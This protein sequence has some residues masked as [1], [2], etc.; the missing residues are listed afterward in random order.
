MARVHG[1]EMKRRS[2]HE[3]SGLI[4][5][6]LGVIRVTWH[7]VEPR[8]TVPIQFGPG[9]ERS[10]PSRIQR[11][12]APPKFF[13]RELRRKLNHF[14]RRPWWPPVF[15][16]TLDEIVPHFLVR[17]AFTHDPVSYI[18]TVRPHSGRSQTSRLM[19]RR[20]NRLAINVENDLAVT[21]A[22]IGP[23]ERQALPDINA[24]HPLHNGPGMPM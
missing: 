16:Q 12:L 1:A 8:S 23:E 11:S 10:L 19:P 4:T 24:A 5:P 18:A 6:P 20:A 9:I 7:P 22:A 14:G 2:S 21:P 3:L 13:R 17:F 15:P